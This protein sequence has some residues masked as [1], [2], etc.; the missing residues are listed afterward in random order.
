MVKGILARIAAALPERESALVGEYFGGRLRLTRLAV[1]AG[2]NTCAVER[3]VAALA[4]DEVFVATATLKR[5][6]AKFGMRRG[7]RLFLVLDPASA[8]TVHAGVTILRQRPADPIDEADLDNLI[9]Q[10]IWKA[11][12]RYR[13][14]AAAKMDTG[15]ID[16]LLTDARVRRILLDGHR[17]VNP[18]GFPARAVEFHFVC[19]MCPRQFIE[20]MRAALPPGQGAT[21]V[22][23]GALYAEAALPAA[24]GDPFLF[25][26][27]FGGRTD[28][29]S[30]EGASLAY[31]ESFPWGAENVRRAVIES[32]GVTPSSAAALLAAY[33]AD[34]ASPRF[35]RR[36][37]EL[38]LGELQMFANGIS[39][40]LE[41]VP[42]KAVYVNP[43]S[44][45]PKVLF[46]S[47]FERRLSRRARLVGMHDGYAERAWGI[48]LRGRGWAPFEN[49]FAVL[50]PAFIF[51]FGGRSDTMVE[52]MARRHTR[53]FLQN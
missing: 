31:L 27:V 30:V 43:F 12:D 44:A 23:N 47:G 19:T 36:F 15:E 32:C 3:S 17:V 46:A 13:R 51:H 16:V 9:G 37:E 33:A 5:L 49:R 28:V 25:A 14:R 53:W 2:R 39:M 50:A 18:L 21:F 20:A 45:L 10:G 40:I 22:E 34:D 35:L 11:F 26:N 8:T 4:S 6:L 1:D 7:E 29:W 38:L 24:K 41:R 48:G 42:A 52:H